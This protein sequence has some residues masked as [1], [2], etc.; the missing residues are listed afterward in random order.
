MSTFEEILKKEFMT[1][2]TNINVQNNV[3]EV[4]K[5]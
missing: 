5:N 1:R 2:A 4:T 3:I